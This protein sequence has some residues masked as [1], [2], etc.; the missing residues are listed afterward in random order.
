MTIRPATTK[1]LSILLD[2]EQKIIEAERPMDPT[3]IQDKKI[4]YYSIED[5]ILSDHTEVVVA[6]IEGEI[7][8]SGYG[9]I[10][11]RKNFF[12]Q[13]QLGYI[14]FMYVKDQHRGKGV[15]QEI[16]KHLCDWFA[17]KN[18]EEIRLTVYDQNPRAIRAYEKVG[19]KKHLI[20]M[21][22]NLKDI[23]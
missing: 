23:N 16:I 11:D 10:R 4:N 18:L 14:G 1:D 22:V 2:F 6:E 7:V 19:F 20:E 3:L 5:Y 9:Q 17:S 15:S 12:K 13:K 8:G 21:R